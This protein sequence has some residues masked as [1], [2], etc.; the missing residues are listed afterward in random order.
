MEEERIEHLEQFWKKMNGEH[1]ALSLKKIAIQSELSPSK[2]TFVCI[3]TDR[4]TGDSLGPMVGS[5]L[6]ELGYPSV[7]GTLKAPCDAS[8]LVMRLEE[9]PQGTMVIAIDACLGQKLSVGMYQLS[10]QPLAPGKSVG[11]V[12]PPIGDYTIAAIVNADG[13]RQYNILQTTSLYYVLN[14]ADE[15]TKAISYGIPVQV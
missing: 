6:A 13:P 1:L 2:V 3:G 10:N 9:I 12:L 15:V 8:N 14:M 4:S 5:K 7:I 11:K